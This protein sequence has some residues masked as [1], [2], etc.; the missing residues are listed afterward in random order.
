MLSDPEPPV[1]CE[2]GVRFP[3]LETMSRKV[4]SFV[5]LLITALAYA[6]ANSLGLAMVADGD[7][8]S[9]IWPASGIAVA[10]FVL[11]GRSAW[12]CIL[13]GALIHLPHSGAFHMP[14]AIA[15][16]LGNALSAYAGALLLR[17]TCFRPSFQA[18]CDVV[19]FTFCGAA[20]PMMLSASIGMASLTIAGA[21]TPAEALSQWWTWW[22]ADTVGVLV[23]APFLILWFG[24]TQHGWR[25]RHLLEIGAAVA[26]LILTSVMFLSS[27]IVFGFIPLLLWGTLRFTQRENA[28]AVLLVAA[29]ATWGSVHD[30]TPMMLLSPYDHFNSLDLFCAIF[31]TTI[32]TGGA[33]VGE[34]RRADAAFLAAHTRQ[35]SESESRFRSAFDGAGTG[36]AIGSLEGRW[37]RINAATSRMLGYSEAELLATTY[38]SITHP[39]DLAQNVAH[40]E[41][42]RDGSYDHCCFEK[43]YIHKNGD[44]IWVLL[45]VSLVRR[46]DGTPV[47][48]VVQIQDMTKRRRMEEKLRHSHKMEAVGQLTAG[49]AHDFNN[50]LA[51]VALNLELIADDVAEESFV[52]KRVEVGQRACARGATLT[53]QL[54]TFARKLPLSSRQHDLG[55]L[56][57]SS[58]H[59]LRHALPEN[60]AI[61]TDTGAIPAACL[62]I[63]QGQFDNALLNLGLNAR[64]A[65]PNGGTLHISVAAR[66][67]GADYGTLAKG[68]YVEIALADTG[69]GMP[70]EVLE[71]AFEP[72]FSTKPS[73]Q[74]SGLGLSMAYGFIQQSGGDLRMEST[75]GRGTTVRILLPL[76]DAPPVNV[77][78]VSDAHRQSHGRLRV[79]LVEDIDD[80]RDT[81]KLQLERRGFAVTA[82][83]SGAA[84]LEVLLSEPF[85]LLVTDLGLPGE[86]DGD[87]LADLAAHKAP[88]QKIITMTGYNDGSLM[89]SAAAKSSQT[90]RHLQKPFTAAQMDQALGNLFAEVPARLSR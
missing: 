53:K 7:V 17:A 84:G 77:K 75:E 40:I 82:A 78:A 86:I 62:N 18:P 43:R 65:M 15:I 69:A 52:A 10:A 88:G 5:H 38:H 37:L 50:L 68:R 60:I 46:D 28:T 63:D 71:R 72:F 76:S 25:T 70:V 56:M 1:S 80:V 48:F 11:W 34:R 47:Q 6:G 31:A 51:I 33:V 90:R 4:P 27:G 59:L 32:M 30:A 12:L 55:A 14:V 9:P 20:A 73:H 45:N 85:D 89:E 44:P 64:D 49:V 23:V 26:T 67:I 87:R 61:R 57:Q 16:A 24:H 19:A 39:D 58:V 29:V 83:D 66:D 42:L 79:L 21:I 41:A 22:V 35:L 81:I 54:L 3:T 13:L 74:G 2:S 8:S 36:M